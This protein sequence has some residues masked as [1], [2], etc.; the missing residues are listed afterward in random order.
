MNDNTTPRLTK[1]TFEVMM[2]WPKIPDLLPSIIE[3]DCPLKAYDHIKGY[4]KDRLTLITIVMIQD[5]ARKLIVPS[6][7]L[8][9]ADEVKPRKPRAHIPALR[10]PVSSETKTG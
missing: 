1:P 9:L 2:A 3:T 8:R 7:L 6:H 10:R 5:G 4:R